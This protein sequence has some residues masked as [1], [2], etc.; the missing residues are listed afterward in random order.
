LAELEVGNDVAL[1]AK[2]GVDKGVRATSAD[3][4]ITA[5]LAADQVVA[6][7]ARQRVIEVAAKESIVAGGT[8]FVDRRGRFAVDHIGSP[9]QG[10]A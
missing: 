1:L 2:A 4:E 3:E 9:V 8:D 7:P 10:I 6:V 5:L